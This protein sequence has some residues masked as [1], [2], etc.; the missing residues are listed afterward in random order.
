MKLHNFIGWTCGEIAC[1]NNISFS[2]V[3]IYWLLLKAECPSN[4]IDILLASGRVIWIPYL[5]WF[6]IN[7]NYRNFDSN[8][9]ISV[10]FHLHSFEIRIRRITK[11][12]LSETIEFTSVPQCNLRERIK[13]YF[14]ASKYFIHLVSFPVWSID[15][16]KC[17]NNT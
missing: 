15:L 9:D 12:K 11:C 5:T 3:G 7:W 13:K 1:I 14:C 6:H 4:W 17:L 16:L 8:E 2:A 10:W